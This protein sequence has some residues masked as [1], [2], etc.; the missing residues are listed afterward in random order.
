[1]TKEQIIKDITEK[2]IIIVMEEKPYERQDYIQNANQA[3]SKTADT[4]H[5]KFEQEKKEQAREIFDKLHN[6]YIELTAYGCDS[7]QHT[8]YYDYK[9]RV[10][11]VVDDIEN[12]AKEY[13]VDL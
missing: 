13:G 10:G 12:L 1:M 3:L 2:F 7:T 9:M 11:D 4:L 8:G 5:T 6:H